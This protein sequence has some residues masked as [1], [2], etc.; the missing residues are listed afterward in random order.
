M[1]DVAK[2]IFLDVGHDLQKRR[3][4]DFKDLL[5]CHLTDH[6]RLLFFSLLR[7]EAGIVQT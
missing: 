5:G 3:K 2:K 6:V 4:A 1:I 7:Q